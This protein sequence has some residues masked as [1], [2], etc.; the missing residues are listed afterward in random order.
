MPGPSK[1]HIKSNRKNKTSWRSG[2][3]IDR[4]DANYPL[5]FCKT[6]V[7]KKLKAKRRESFYPA[8]YRF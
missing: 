1:H 8:F 5:M 6:K 7:C 3:Y 2:R 4:R